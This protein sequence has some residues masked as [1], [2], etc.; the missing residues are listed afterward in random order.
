MNTYLR[1]KTDVL[2]QAAKTFRLACS[3]WWAGQRGTFDPR[4][5]QRCRACKRSGCNYERTG[6]SCA[7]LCHNLRGAALNIY[8]LTKTELAGVEQPTPKEGK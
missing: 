7:C 2:D 6:I 8:D 1:A 4:K 5:H 3:Q